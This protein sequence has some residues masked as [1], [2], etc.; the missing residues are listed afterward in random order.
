MIRP[1]AAG[2]RFIVAGA[3]LWMSEIAEMLRR[4]LGPRAVKVSTRKMPTF[5]VKLLAPFNSNSSSLPR[6]SE[7]VLKFL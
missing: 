6:S 1:A 5:V 2:Q 3:Y 4:E 7:S